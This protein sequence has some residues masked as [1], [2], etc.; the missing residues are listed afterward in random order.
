MK[1][2]L[3]STL[4]VLALSGVLAGV[5]AAA[6]PKPKATYTG[7]S[8]PSG[9]RVDETLHVSKTG[10]SGKFTAKCLAYSGEEITIKVKFNKGAFGGQSVDGHGMLNSVV[11][12]FT[13]SKH[14]KGQLNLNECGGH[15]E[16]FKLSLS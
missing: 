11:G 2:Y 10:K 15:F 3:R 6:V 13:T 1:E 16:S 5:A 7:S 4:V 12:Q 8:G 14:A 9:N